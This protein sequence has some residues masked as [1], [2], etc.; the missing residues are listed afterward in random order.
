MISQSIA[1]WGGY[2]AIVLVFMALALWLAHRLLRFAKGPPPVV[3]IPHEAHGCYVE[4]DFSPRHTQ[5]SLTARQQ[6]QAEAHAREF[7]EARK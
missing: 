2:A 3:E 6:K 7:A 5:M 4:A 1:Q